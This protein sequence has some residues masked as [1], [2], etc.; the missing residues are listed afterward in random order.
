MTSSQAFEAT[1]A[2]A[3]TTRYLDRGAGRIG[4]DDT[5]S[6]PLIIAV[7]GMGD[8]RSTYRHLTP[9]LVA[10]GFR[11]AT[12]DLR[13]HGD[14]DTTF[15]DY[16]DPAAASDILALAAHLGGPALIIG[17][18]MGAA[19]AVIAAAEQPSAISGLVLVGPFVRNP[20]ASAVKLLL[21]RAIFGGPWARRAWLGYFPTFF[22]TRRDA[23]FAEH[24]AAIGAAI[25]RPGYGKAFRA[26]TRTSH[27]PAEAALDQ[28]RTPVLVVMGSKD[29]DF[30]GQQAEADFIAGRLHGRVAMIP[31]AG[32][33]PQ[34]EFPELTSPAIVEF[35]RQIQDDPADA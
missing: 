34:A 1:S 9:V 10:A 20:P 11:V 22:P 23:D 6:G 29:P 3:S 18:S 19:A 33:Y 25:A 15:T 4:Y 28:V 12:M 16:D 30:S 17:N 26:T 5:G 35:A 21:F 14:S 8:L 27:D 7:P 31:D 13:G 24:R 32:H 2:S